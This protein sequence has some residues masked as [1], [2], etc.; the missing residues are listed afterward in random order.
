M[1][2]ELITDN[3]IQILLNLSNNLWMKTSL[4]KNNC[5][6]MYELI[7]RIYY[8]VIMKKFYKHWFNL[9]TLMYHNY[10]TGCNQKVRHKFNKLLLEVV[11]YLVSLRIVKLLSMM[12]H[13][14]SQTTSYILLQ[15]V[16]LRIS[17]LNLWNLT[18]IIY[19][20]I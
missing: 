17:E 19:R 8:L 2:S 4:H 5:N 14:C 13:L 20:I 3:L 9:Y 16:N 7:L 1:L 15:I 18:Q 12:H 6:N 11:L 10:L